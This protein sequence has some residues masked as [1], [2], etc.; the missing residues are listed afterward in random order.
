MNEHGQSSKEGLLLRSTEPSSKRET[1]QACRKP[2]DRGTWQT[3]P[4]PD[5]GMQHVGSLLFGE[6]FDCHQMVRRRRCC[7]YALNSIAKIYTPS[8]FFPFP[9]SSSNPL[10]PSPSFTAP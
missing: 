4:Y 5:A 9:S 3:L 2:N 6:H 10:S 8:S 1:L 7:W